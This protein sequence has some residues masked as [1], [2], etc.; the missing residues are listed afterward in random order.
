MLQWTAMNAR[1]TKQP[2]VAAVVLAAGG[3]TRMGRTKQ[4]LPIK[5]QPMVHRVVQAVCTAGLA[6]V[7]VVLGAQ[8]QA[9]GE[10][11]TDLPV[12]I[13]I[14][15]AWAAGLSTSVRAGL[16]AL[17]DEVQAVLMILGDQPALSPDLLHR[18]VE[19]YRASDAPIVAPVFGGR[20][21]NPVLFDRRLFAELAA[22]EGDRGGR[23][24]LQTHAAQVEWVTVTDEAILLDIDTPDDYQVWAD[25]APASQ[26]TGP[27]R[28]KKGNG[29]ETMDQDN[30][31]LDTIQH[32]I[33]DMD[34]VLYRGNEPI[35][36]T[37]ALLDFL[38][39]EKIGFLLA[40]NNATRTPEQFVAKLAG[41][42][43]TVYPHE[44]L[45]SSIA[46]AGYLASIAPS[47]TRVF[48][49]G[50]DGLHAALR[51]AGFRLV[52]RDAEYVVVGM[53]FTICYDRLRDAT[54][55]IR[56]GATFIGTN[57]DKTFPSELGIVPGAGSLLAFLEAATGVKPT[58]IGKPGRTMIEQALKR[59]GARAE[60]TAMLGDRLETDILGGQRSGLLTIL[61]LSGV[62][63]RTLLAGS[64]I[65]PD[66]V[67]EDVAHLQAVWQEA[68]RR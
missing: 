8:A 54:L 36:G 19:R 67:F 33:I 45:T 1:G 40:T 23:V 55:E 26:G 4:L 64:E 62:T 13:V 27:S 53:D 22:I 49:V 32:I 41:M 2:Q 44:I 18:L 46:T 20:R 15:D 61:V 57:P 30:S 56:A 59:L 50:Q 35:P 37:A 42:G 5:G 3:S 25:Q 52:D 7:V 43:V 9:I 29:S 65:Q 24:L 68:R 31:K 47:G 34:G 10:T 58:I 38:R 6:Q 17:R 51:E 48:V 21:G 66:L 63:D 16:A 12:E 60:T 39:R 28:Q 11:L 14:N